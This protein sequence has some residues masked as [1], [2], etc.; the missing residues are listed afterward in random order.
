MPI[1]WGIHF[2][3]AFL[4]TVSREIYRKMIK[5][6]RTDHF[7]V[8]IFLIEKSNVRNLFY[9]KIGVNALNF[10]NE[11]YM[12]SQCT[13]RYSVVL[14]EWDVCILY[15]GPKCL[16]ACVMHLWN[17]LCVHGTW[18]LACMAIYSIYSK[19]V[20]YLSL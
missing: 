16:V 14:Y 3:V 4:S 6:N 12:H 15:G 20:V 18:H 2:I 10:V 8:S 1:N 7:L 11:V 13:N 5:K 9:R 19:L 17:W